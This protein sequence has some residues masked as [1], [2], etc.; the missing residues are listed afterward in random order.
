MISSLGPLFGR[1]AYLLPPMLAEDDVAQDVS[2]SDLAAGLMDVAPHAQVEAALAVVERLFCTMALLHAGSAAQGQWRFS[3]YSAWLVARSLLEALSTD[4]HTL[5]DPGYWSHQPA[6]IEVEEQRELLKRLENGRVAY[7]PGNAARPIRFVYVA[8]AVIR[9]DDRFLLYA[10]EDKVRA[11]AR[12]HFG[13]PGGRFKLSDAPLAERP[14]TAVHDFAYGVGHWPMAH[15]Q[16]SLYR[17]LR[18]ELELSER[19]HYSLGPSIDITPYSR[20]EGARNHHSYTEYRMRLFPLQL[21]SH[22]AIKLFE[23]LHRCPEL[24]AWFTADELGMERNTRGQRAFVTALVEHFGPELKQL[25]AL[26]Q[27]IAE[28][29]LLNTPHVGIDIPL[30]PEWPVTSGRSGKPSK[31]HRARLTVAEHRWLWAL[32]WHAKSL[33]FA[34]AHNVGLLPLGWIRIDDIAVVLS[35]R[36]KLDASGLRLV[37][38]EDGRYA[39]LSI[40]PRMVYFDPNF[41]RYRLHGD[42]IKG[43]LELFSVE[44]DTPLGL[45]KHESVYFE[46]NTTLAGELRHLDGVE[47]LADN[48]QSSEHLRRMLDAVMGEATKNMGVRQLIAHV[49]SARQHRILLITKDVTTSDRNL[50]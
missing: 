12:G 49:D 2:R 26:P 36:D 28:T 11:D 32:A 44:I 38:I 7:H 17:E 9:L 33:P 29:H 24:F 48:T 18:E 5:L 3:S 4:H 34:G 15:L 41:F 47:R 30:A 14:A 39:R 46:L 6:D 25:V 37:E 31:E 45:L 27:A 35:L 19:D 22:G 43:R 50:G 1:L 42:A 40:N 20:I 23:R 10:R 13:L 16:R 8:W 21:N